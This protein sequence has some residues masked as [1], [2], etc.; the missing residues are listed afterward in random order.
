MFVVA[1]AVTA[2]LYPLVIV[3]LGYPPTAPAAKV[4]G[5]VFSHTANL[6]ITFAISYET[7]CVVVVYNSSIVTYCSELWIALAIWSSRLTT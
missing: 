3:V 7:Q 4:A 5:A 1:G 2:A 6:V